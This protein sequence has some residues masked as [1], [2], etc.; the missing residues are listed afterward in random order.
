[1]T[2]ERARRAILARRAKFL[3][4]ALATTL[5]ACEREKEGIQ[6]DHA[7]VLPMDSGTPATSPAAE[8]ATAPMPCLQIVAEPD[9][10]TKPTPTPCLRLPRPTDAGPKP[11]PCLKIAVDDD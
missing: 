1:M 10:G 9:A 3:A 8:D 6:P 4:A 2:D 5:P 7:K 11:H